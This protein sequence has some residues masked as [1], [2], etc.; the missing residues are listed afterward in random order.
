MSASLN[1]RW[2]VSRCFFRAW[3]VRKLRWQRQ[4][5][6]AALITWYWEWSCS[7]STVLKARLH[8]LQRYLYTWRSDTGSWG[9]LA[10]T[11]LKCVWR[12]AEVLKTWLHPFFQHRKP[13]SSLTEPESTGE[14]FKSPLCSVLTEGKMFF[15]RSS[16]V[17]VKKIEIKPNDK[18][19]FELPT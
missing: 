2:L 6:V 17:S 8:W 10:W 1:S 18:E 4:H 9:L 12:V 13:E 16:E 19:G 7:F 3:K 11:S 5:M 15:P 14:G